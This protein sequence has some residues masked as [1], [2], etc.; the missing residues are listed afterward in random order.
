MKV[1]VTDGDNRAALAVT[2]ALGRR[3]HEVVVAEKRIPSLAQT[4]RYCAHRAVY[5]DP[6]RHDVEFIRSLAATV[7]S[8]QVD[9]LLPVADITTILVT[10]HRAAFEPRCQVP[11]AN[12]DSILRAADKVDMLRTANRIGV[13]TPACHFLAGPDD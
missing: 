5:P 2:R 12:A 9:I 10:E 1:L 7:T 8:E 13:P 11:F 4:S 3:G 6:A